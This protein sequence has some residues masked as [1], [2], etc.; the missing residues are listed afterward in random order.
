MYSAYSWFPTREHLFAHA[1]PFAD[2]DPTLASELGQPKVYSGDIYSEMIL[3]NLVHTS[4]VLLRRER[5]ERVRTFDTSLRRS[6][7]DYDFHL[8]TCREGPVAYLDAPS[9]LYT[10]GAADQLTSPKHRIDMARNHVQTITPV[11]AAD[12]ARIRLPKVMLDEVLAEAHGWFGECLYDLGERAAARRELLTS[13]RHKPKQPRLA[14]F[15]ALTLLPF[16]SDLLQGFH[17]AKSLMRDRAPATGRPHA[18]R[19]KP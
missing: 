4:T 18:V 10:W 19:G 5:F 17:R 3:G 13:L 6:G 2:L 11:I 9:I 15:A 7:E 1:F 12:R 14:V 8:R 16:S